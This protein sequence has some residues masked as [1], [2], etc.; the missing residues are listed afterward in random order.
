[1]ERYLRPE[2]FFTTLDLL[3]RVS[4]IDEYSSVIMKDPLY[5]WYLML[6]PSYERDL[7]TIFSKIGE[8]WKDGFFDRMCHHNLSKDM[9]C[10]FNAYAT[11]HFAKMIYKLSTGKF[12]L[13]LPETGKEWVSRHGKRNSTIPDTPFYFD[14]AC[15]LRV[16]RDFKIEPA[17]WTN[18]RGLWNMSDIFPDASLGGMELN[19]ELYQINDLIF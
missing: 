16:D 19:I 8:R 18:L 14:N 6:Q 11:D 7:L 3:K 2:S 5:V 9:L 15:R 13:E 1:M 12:I 17:E 10:L 4:S